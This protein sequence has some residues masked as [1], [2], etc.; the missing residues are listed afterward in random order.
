MIAAAA[1]TPLAGTLAFWIVLLIFFAGA[2]ALGKV[3]MQ[4]LGLKPPEWMLSVAYVVAFVVF[5]LICVGMIGWLVDRI[6]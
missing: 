4:H 6:R 1:P 2:V 5:M 3:G